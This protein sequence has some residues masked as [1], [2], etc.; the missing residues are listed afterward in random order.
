MEPVAYRRE[1]AKTLGCHV[2][3][4]PRE[5][6]PVAAIGELTQGEGADAT[7]DCTGL[8]LP[9]TQSVRS[10]RIYGRACLVGEGGDTTF[11]VSR[12]IIHK[13]LN[14]T[15]SWTMSTICLAEVA[16]YVAERKIP[17]K[18]M[19]THRFRL[20][21]AVEAYRTF[22]SGETGKVVFTWA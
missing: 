13:Q 8:P 18:K 22:E 15:G 2:A 5:A 21:Q 14:L 4:D 7:L 6:D 12:D 20:E 9:R 10:T 17:L 11:D 1:L 3:L 19:I 16:H